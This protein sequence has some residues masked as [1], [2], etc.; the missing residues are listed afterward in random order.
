MLTSMLL[1]HV[2]RSVCITEFRYR[3]HL[4]TFFLDHIDGH[5]YRLYN[6]SGTLFGLLCLVDMLQL[7]FSML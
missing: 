7:G 1:G 6:F 2:P 3:P 5:I 4:L